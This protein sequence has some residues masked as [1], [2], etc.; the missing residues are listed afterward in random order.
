MFFSSSLVEPFCMIPI[1]MTV[2]SRFSSIDLAVKL[3]LV[4]LFFLLNTDVNK[5][6]NCCR[7]IRQLTL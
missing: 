3:T 4:Y 5:A 1:C 2:E 7:L 6:I